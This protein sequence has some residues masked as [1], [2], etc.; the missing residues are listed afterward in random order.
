MH[1][2]REKDERERSTI[3]L[4]EN[5][6][7]VTEEAAGAELATNVGDDEDEEGDHDGEIEVGSMTEALE[8][9]YA[10]LEV[11]AGDIEAENVAG[12]AGDPAQPVAGVCDGEDPVEDEGPSEEACVRVEAGMVM[13]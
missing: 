1:K 4:E 10:L 8:D 5:T 6:D 3:V 12:E 11:D 7:P 2:A 9:L 13:R